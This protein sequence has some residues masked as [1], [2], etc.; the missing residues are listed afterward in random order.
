MV[1]IDV[2]LK[3]KINKRSGHETKQSVDVV[4]K[5]AGDSWKPTEDMLDSE[6]TAV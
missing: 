4:E 2:K 1:A 6:K 3:M 5:E